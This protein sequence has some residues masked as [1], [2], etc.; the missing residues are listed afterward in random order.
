MQPQNIPFAEGQMLISR[1]DCIQCVA[2]SG[3]L[4]FVMVQRRATP[5]HN[6]R[7]TLIAGDDALDGIGAFD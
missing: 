1:M 4:R 3:D 5:V 2:V 7:N 6:F